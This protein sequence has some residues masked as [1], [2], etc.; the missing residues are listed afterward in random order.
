MK[1]MLFIL[2][3]LSILFAVSTSCEKTELNQEMTDQQQEQHE[4][5]NPTEL[6]ISFSIPNA[7]ADTLLSKQWQYDQTNVWYRDEIVSSTEENFIFWSGNMILGLEGIRQDSTIAPTS[8][9]VDN[10][11]YLYVSPFVDNFINA[12]LPESQIGFEQPMIID[13]VVYYFVVTDVFETVM[14]DMTF[15][16][17]IRFEIRRDIMIFET[18]HFELLVKPKDDRLEEYQSIDGIQGFLQ[19]FTIKDVAVKVRSYNSE[20]TIK[21][22]REKINLE[23]TIVNAILMYHPEIGDTIEIPS[24][25]N[26]VSNLMIRATL[27]AAN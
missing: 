4:M 5:A 24:T 27:V 17:E 25:E 6:E 16:T 9:T 15:A 26:G 10:L 21:E 3:I 22:V 7:Q 2:G 11:N 12:G 14:N 19:G 8:D 13:E 23:A 18:E 20:D 1:K